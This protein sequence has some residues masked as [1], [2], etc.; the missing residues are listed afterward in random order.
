MST[1]AQDVPTEPQTILL[2]Y[3]ARGAAATGTRFHLTVIRA[4]QRAGWIDDRG[5]IHKI[6][7]EALARGLY[8][9]RRANG[10]KGRP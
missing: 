3:A 7:H 1:Q 2:E 9:R 6:G 8:R 10:K 4:C 5:F